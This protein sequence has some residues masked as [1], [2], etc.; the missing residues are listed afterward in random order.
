MAVY[1][2][3]RLGS[4]FVSNSPLKFLHQHEYIVHFYLFIISTF[5]W[6]V[7]CYSFVF[8]PYA[9]LTNL[10]CSETFKGV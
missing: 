10:G 2:S 9:M 5:V 7:L 1:C 3:T 4:D 8:S 6:K